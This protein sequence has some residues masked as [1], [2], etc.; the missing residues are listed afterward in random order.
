MGLDARALG[1][2]L[3]DVECA[4]VA[5]RDHARGCRRCGHAERRCLHAN[6]YCPAGRRW[7]LRWRHAR[8]RLR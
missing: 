4:A 1:V 6:A 3:H 2:V 5:L 7:L 8:L